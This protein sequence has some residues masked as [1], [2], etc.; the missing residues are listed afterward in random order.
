M[1]R[2]EAHLAWP[3]LSL[4]GRATPNGF[5][6]VTMYAGPDRCGLAFFLDVVAAIPD[7]GPSKAVAHH[8]GRKVATIGAANHD[9]AAVA[10]ESSSF[11]G[12]LAVAN[13]G[14]QMLGGSLSCVHLGSLRC[15]QRPHHSRDGEA[16][17]Q[18]R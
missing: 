12:N 15:H 4:L 18:Q 10:V 3:E 2:A 17:V 14:A 7:E 11:A 5:A 13:E 8:V 16:R 9:C 1:S 6:G